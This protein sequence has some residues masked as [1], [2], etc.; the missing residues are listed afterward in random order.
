MDGLTPQAHL[1]MSG[2]VRVLAPLPVALTFFTPEGERQ[3]VPGWEPE[4]LH[5]L[6]GAL[7]AGLTFRTQHHGELT[8]WLVSR[9]DLSAGEIEYVRITPDSRMGTVS[10]RCAATASGDTE[11]TVT[12]KLTALSIAAE[13]T[14][15]RFAAEFESMLASWEEMIAECLSKGGETADAARLEVLR[16]DITTLDV[17]AI[18]NAA[19]EGLFGGGGVDGAVHRA[20]G[21]SLLAACRAV[22]E[23]RPAIRCPTGE[24]RITPGFRLPARHVVHTA[25]PVWKGGSHAEADL[26]AMCYRNALTLAREQRLRSVAFAA[27]SCGVYGY[28]VADAARIAVRETRAFLAGNDTP[29]RVVLVAFDEE[30]ED[31]LRTALEEIPA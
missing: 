22:P 13:A 26:L 29:Q 21:P 1:E 31:A 15:A 20:A 3:W 25:G 28:P 24:A 11:A 16:G 7:D 14:L 8:L 18:V 27:I 5:P 17:D 30:I 6:N 19:N 23:V 9:C 12:Y 4:Y 10:I 2:R